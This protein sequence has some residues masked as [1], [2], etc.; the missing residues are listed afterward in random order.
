M[1]LPLD[2]TID[3]LR[4]YYAAQSKAER[5]DQ[6]FA[7][8]MRM[9]KTRADAWVQMLVLALNN[10]SFRT[11]MRGEWRGTLTVRNHVRMDLTEEL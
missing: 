3:M 6:G 4:S 9:Y 1:I 10:A 2:E 8:A 7:L 11:R 5:V